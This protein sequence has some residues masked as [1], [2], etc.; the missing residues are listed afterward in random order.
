[1]FENSDNIR[2]TFSIDHLASSNAEEPLGEHYT[3]C[4][5]A[6]SYIPMKMEYFDARPKIETL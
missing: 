5:V 1:V 3:V 6:D 4:I 2:Q